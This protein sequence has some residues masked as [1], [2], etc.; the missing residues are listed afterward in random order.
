MITLTETSPRLKDGV[1]QTA[2]PAESLRIMVNVGCAGSKY[3]MGLE[4]V[5]REGD[6]IIKRDGVNVFVDAGFQPH[7]AGMSFDFVTGLK[8]SGFVFDNPNAR[9]KCACGKSLG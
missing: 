1:S 2:E 6:A 8:A 5:S 3:L 7:V 4:S 9:G